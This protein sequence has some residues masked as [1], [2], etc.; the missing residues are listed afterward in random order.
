MCNH[1]SNVQL[2]YFHGCQSMVHPYMVYFKEDKELKS[3]S[4][5]WIPHKCTTFQKNFLLS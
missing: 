4:Y 3:K 1:P 2:S 5:W